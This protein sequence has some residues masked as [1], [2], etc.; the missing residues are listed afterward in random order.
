MKKVLII[1]FSSI[2][3]IVLTSPVIRCLKGQLPGVEIHFLTKKQYYPILQSNPYLSK[4]W[5]YDDNFEELIPLLRAENFDFIADLHKNFRSKYIL[6]RLMKPNHSFPKLDLKKWLLVR[7]KIDRLPK[8]H[9]ADRYFEALNLFGIS[10]D[11]KGLDYFIPENEEVD[12]VKFMPSR[13]T[14]YIAFS[15]AGKHN[16][17]ILP[18]EKVVD[19]CKAMNRPV[20]L[21]GGNEDKARGER[22]QFQSGNH[23]MNGCGMFSINQS[24]SL[25]MQAEKVI[26]NDTG[27]MHIAAAFKKP[28]LSV[29]GNTVP[30]FGMYPYL[31][32]DQKQNSYIFEVNGLSCRPCSKLGYD[33]CPKG[34]FRCMNDQDV[35]KMINVLKR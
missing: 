5:S 33:H 28:V 26:T 9:I 25:I 4:I 13:E 10:N 11:G 14:G 30:E 17:K 23:V 18:E 20:I 3:D 29:W 27:L 7:F 15:I 19:I 16:T 8:I 12:P 35:T 32:E 1:R 34:H 31:P 22:I 2:G 24:A 21:L 6:F